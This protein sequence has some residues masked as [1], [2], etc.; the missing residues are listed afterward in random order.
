VSL[1]G[2]SL[3]AAKDIEGEIKMWKVLGV[4]AAILLII[5]FR[6]GQN[7]VW[8]GLSLGV[9]VGLIIAVVLAF[10]GNGFNWLVI[11]KTIT[12]GTI[13]GFLADLLGKVPKLFR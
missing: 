2:T 9:I 6:K 11:L 10:M 7:S 3:E 5:N 13:V 4:I 12:I 8:G 1:W